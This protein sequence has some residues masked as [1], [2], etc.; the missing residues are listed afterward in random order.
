METSPPS[1]HRTL[2]LYR[3]YAL[4]GLTRRCSC[5]WNDPRLLIMLQ[6]CRKERTFCEIS[7][8]F[9]N[10]KNPMSFFIIWGS[11]DGGPSA[12][13]NRT[14]KLHATTLIGSAGISS[15]LALHW[16]TRLKKNAGDTHSAHS[17]INDTPRSALPLFLHRH[18]EEFYAQLSHRWVKIIMQ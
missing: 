10:H 5:K 8:R 9:S 15:L 6:S 1:N 3:S 12:M 2:H 17:I 11:V 4:P 16:G 13:G 7:C 14:M 18:L